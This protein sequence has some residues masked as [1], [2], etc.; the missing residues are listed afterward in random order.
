SIPA[1]IDTDAAT[2][3]RAGGVPVLESTRTGLLALR[4]LLAH[5]AA[6]H[7]ASTQPDDST[8]AAASTVAAA[9]TGAAARAQAHGCDIHTPIAVSLPQP[10]AAPRV[11]RGAEGEPWDGSESRAGSE[12]DQTR[13]NR[14]TERLAAGPL[15]GA[16]LFGLLRD[17]GIPAVA[18]RFAGTCYEALE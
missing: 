9:S 3:L 16:A 11:P 10:S 13:R 6:T 2:R 15:G 1:A 17:Y 7:A 12:R 8:G 5:T 4:H 18:A 14:W